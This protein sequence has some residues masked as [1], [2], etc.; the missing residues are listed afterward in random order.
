MPRLFFG[1]GLDGEIAERVCAQVRSVLFDEGAEA[2]YRAADLHLTLAFLGDVD[3]SRLPSI[4]SAALDEFRGLTAPE[5]RLGG[6][7]EG[8]PN[9]SEPRAI[10][11]DVEETF[12]SAGRLSAIRNRVHQ[13]A[14]SHGWRPSSKERQRGFRPHVTLARL[15]GKPLSGGEVY[16]LSIERN[17]LPVDITLFES[18][19]SRGDGGDRYRIH[20]TWPLVVRPG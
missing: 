20:A 14:L 9:R 10:F 11:A 3:E 12:D 1:L 16:D 17:W 2:I 6:D 15:G 18:L 8:F 19:G 4:Q 5:L 13:V 7:I